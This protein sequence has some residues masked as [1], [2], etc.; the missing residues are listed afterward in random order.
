MQ[1]GLVLLQTLAVGVLL[2]SSVAT[3]V[4]VWRMA[5]DT[6]QMRLG[7]EALTSDVSSIRRDVDG[8]ESGQRD[9]AS[10]VD[11]IKRDVDWIESG[12]STMEVRIVR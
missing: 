2:A 9:V 7:V 8:L 5:E 11:A 1:R 10:D 6:R 4:L 12:L 3:T